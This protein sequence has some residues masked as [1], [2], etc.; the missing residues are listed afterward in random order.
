MVIGPTPLL[1]L[2]RRQAG[3]HLHRRGALIVIGTK[4]G[5]GGG[6]QT[7]VVKW[8]KYTKTKIFGKYWT[9]IE[10]NGCKKLRMG[11]SW[12][13]IK[14]RLIWGGVLKDPVCRSHKQKRERRMTPMLPPFLRPGLLHAPTFCWMLCSPSVYYWIWF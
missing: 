3:W 10:W 9:G 12:K 13:Q 5:I 1:K 8:D 14:T 7:R 11:R 6:A 4:Q 2:R